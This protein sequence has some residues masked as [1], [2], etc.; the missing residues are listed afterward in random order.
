ML[1]LQQGPVKVLML[2]F[3]KNKA[4]KTGILNDDSGVVSAITDGIIVDCEYEYDSIPSTKPKFNEYLGTSS[5][6]RFSIPPLSSTKYKEDTT[7][8][9]RITIVLMY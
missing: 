9:A 1:F 4:E 3:T 5:M 6:L 2:E 7:K 8:K